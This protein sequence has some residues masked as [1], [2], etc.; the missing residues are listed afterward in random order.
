M[1]DQT[2]PSE[3]VLRQIGWDELRVDELAAFGDPSLRPA[4]CV[5]IDRGSARALAPAGE[6][7]V[8]TSQPLAVGDW[9]ALSEG[10]LAHV[11]RRRGEIARRASGGVGGRQI[12]AAN[13][14]LLLVVASLDR[15]VKAGRLRR[16]VAL[17]RS[18]DAA[19]VVVLTKADLHADPDAIAAAVASAIGVEVVSVAAERGAGLDRLRSLVEPS[20]TMVLVGESGAG[21]ST[22]VNA[23]AGTELETGEVRGGDAKGRHT[24][25]WRE[26]VALPGGGAIIDTPGVREIGL[27]DPGGVDEAFA[28]VLDVAGGCRFSDCRHAEEPGCA[29][30]AAAD[31]GL[32]D[33]GDLERMRAMRIEAEAAELRANEHERRRHER[34]FARRVREAQRDKRRRGR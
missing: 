10:R 33:P 28:D 13:V 9:I 15:P 12:I 5:R 19:P 29:L 25:T 8:A 4:R 11:L 2:R 7:R 34:R 16:A 23:L 18:G 14:D 27:V 6:V 30:V 20:R 22:L 32:V 17:A 3:H 24:T 31:A 26:L 1:P 21:K